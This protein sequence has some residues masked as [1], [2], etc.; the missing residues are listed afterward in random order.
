MRNLK[1]DCCKGISIISIVMFH[2]HLLPAFICAGTFVFNLF[3]FVFAGLMF[4][5]EIINN[6]NDLYDYFKKIF[7]RYAKPYIISNLLFLISYNFFVKY[8]FIM[9]DNKY[10]YGHLLSLGEILKKSFSHILVI[11]HAEV[12]NGASWFLKSLFWG[13]L[14]YSFAILLCNILN[15]IKTLNGINLRY[16]LYFL[17]FIFGSYI[18]YITDNTYVLFLY[19]SLTC[20]F[21][22]DLLKRLI[23][24]FKFNPVYYGASILLIAASIVITDKQFYFVSL[25][26]GGFSSFYFIYATSIFLEKFKKIFNLFVFLGQNTLPILLLHLI[27][28]KLI[29]FIYINVYSLPKSDLGFFPVIDYSGTFFVAVLWKIL[30]LTSGIVIPVILFKLFSIKYPSTKTEK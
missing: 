24:N 20:I 25:L 17:I 9:I 12:L 4:K 18:V 16:T 1:Y 2:C 7:K 26:I 15:K 21:I 5:R 23:Q 29:T 8:H 28:F 3:F 30:Y 27:S 13:L 19:I 6:F 14:L 10:G 22:G 11:S